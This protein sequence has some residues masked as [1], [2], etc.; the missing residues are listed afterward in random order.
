VNVH[1]NVNGFSSVCSGLTPAT[2][3]VRIMRALPDNSGSPS[4]RDAG[5]VTL[6][7]TATRSTRAPPIL[8]ESLQGDS[9]SIQMHRS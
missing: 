2:R 3:S 8:G 1:V 5:R 4:P 6:S 7:R 9:S